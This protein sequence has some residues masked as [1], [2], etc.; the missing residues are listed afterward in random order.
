LGFVSHEAI[1]TA[2]LADPVGAAIVAG[3]RMTVAWNE[4]GLVI[5]RG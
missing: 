4:G 3:A 1:V 5:R 2:I